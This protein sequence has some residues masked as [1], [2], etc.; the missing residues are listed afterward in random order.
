MHRTD[1]HPPR[2]MYHATPWISIPLRRSKIPHP[3]YKFYFMDPKS[4]LRDHK[5]MPVLS[6][7]SQILVSA[8]KSIPVLNLGSQIYTSA[9]SA[10]TNPF[11]RSV[12]AQKST[13]GIKSPTQGFTILI[14]LSQVLVAI[15]PILVIH[16]YLSYRSH[17]N[18]SHNTIA[19]N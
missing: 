15:F 13:S 12:C 3:G 1:S 18:K 17:T 5:S 2:G 19:S 7:Y 8:N 14:N 6:L 9:Q 4:D 16:V 10:I 11:Q